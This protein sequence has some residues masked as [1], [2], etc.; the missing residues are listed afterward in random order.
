MTDGSGVEP[1]GSGVE[2]VGSGVEPDGSGVEPVETRRPGP[3]VHRPGVLAAPGVAE[4]M[5][6]LLRPA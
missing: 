1:V 3:G 5:S 4:T 6:A 2:P